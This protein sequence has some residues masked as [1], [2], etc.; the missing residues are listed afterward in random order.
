MSPSLRL[1]VGLGSSALVACHANP[2]GE[3]DAGTDAA[4]CQTPAGEL[5]DWQPPD[6]AVS[7]DGDLPGGMAADGGPTGMDGG[8]ME[9][10]GRMGTGAL[11]MTDSVIPDETGAAAT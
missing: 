2:P 6:G 3:P 9:T 4:V 7:P 1:L 5:E 10:G 11:G 8:G